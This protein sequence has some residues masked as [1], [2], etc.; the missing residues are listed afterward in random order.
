ML[1]PPLSGETKPDATSATDGAAAA[2]SS[3]AA[4]ILLGQFRNE[5]CC[6]RCEEAS[7][8][9][10]GNVLRC[11]GC[12]NGYHPACLDKHDQQEQQEEEKWRCPDCLAGIHPCFLCKLSEGEV[13]VRATAKECH[14]II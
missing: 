14:S 2:E 12:Q 4:P 5:R 8:P 7:S 11:R 13:V 3:A 9:E 1:P 6:I 10:L